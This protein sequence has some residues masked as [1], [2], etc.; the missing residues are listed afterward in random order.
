MVSED[1]VREKAG[2]VLEGMTAE[3]ITAYDISF[4]ADSKEDVEP[5]KEVTVTIS[6]PLSADGKYKLIHIPDEGEGEPTE[7]KNAAFTEKGVTF[8]SKDFSVYAVVEIEIPVE[9]GIYEKENNGI[10]VTVTT[11]NGT[12]SPLELI[13]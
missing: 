13:V 12:F 4:H 2:N 10:R 3:S 11:S 5:N 6:M 9:G 7:V 1:V 8:T